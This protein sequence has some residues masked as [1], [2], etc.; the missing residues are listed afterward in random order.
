MRTPLLLLILLLAG[1]G[2][3]CNDDGGR[4]APD[5]RLPDEWA[6]LLAHADSMELLSLYPRGGDLS[7]A[8]DDPDNSPGAPQP[9][10]PA[11]APQFHEYPVLGR[12]ALTPAEAAAC[13]DVIQRAIANRNVNEITLCFNPRH[14]LIATRNGGTLEL[15]ICFECIAIHATGPDGTRRGFSIRSADGNDRFN[16]ILRTAGI[17]LAPEH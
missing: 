4:S 12:N 14:G 15:V 5:N 7:E 8:R 16:A 1:C 11:D 2:S 13:S 3:G 9:L 17:P 6:D 10:P